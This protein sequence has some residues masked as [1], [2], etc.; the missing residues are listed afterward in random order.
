[1]NVFEPGQLRSIFAQDQLSPAKLEAVFKGPLQQVNG[2]FKLLRFHARILGDV[3]FRGISADVHSKLFV[4]RILLKNTLFVKENTTDIFPRFSVTELY[5]MIMLEHLLA[6]HQSLEIFDLFWSDLAD[7]VKFFLNFFQFVKGDSDRSVQGLSHFTMALR[8]IKA[9]ASPGAL[10]ERETARL[11]TINCFLKFN[12]QIYQ[13]VIA[14]T[15][16]RLA[17]IKQKANSMLSSKPL[18]SLV[19]VKIMREGLEKLMGTDFTRFL[20]EERNCHSDPVPHTQDNFEKDMGASVLSKSLL[21]DES[22]LGSIINLDLHPQPKSDNASSEWPDS[23]LR[24]QQFA[25]SVSGVTLA[26]FIG[27]GQHRPDPRF[28]LS[29]DSSSGCGTVV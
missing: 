26:E 25:W 28:S 1:M 4:Y 10:F 23:N 24:K 19:F 21:G 15:E 11:E 5:E 17:K 27:H 20:K 13:P 29:N 2:K 12:P 22:I 3:S 18:Y 6:S 16:P 9:D 14:S 7:K 8:S